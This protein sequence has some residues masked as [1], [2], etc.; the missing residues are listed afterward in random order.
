MTTLEKRA[1]RQL[2]KKVNRLGGVCY[3]FVSPGNSGVVDRI[4]QMPGAQILFVELKSIGKNLEPL[5]E[6][7]AKRMRDLGF[8]VRCILTEWDL[9]CLL[10]EIEYI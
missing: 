7:Q 10:F 5:Q 9:Q 6:Y 4:V 8:Q 2:R 3:K 1:E